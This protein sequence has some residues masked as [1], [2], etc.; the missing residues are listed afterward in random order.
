[1]N[2]LKIKFATLRGNMSAEGQRRLKAKMYDAG[3]KQM[4]VWVKRKDPKNITSMSRENF[5]EKVDKLTA[6]LSEIE[7]RNLFNM[8]LKIVT[9]HK[10]ELKRK[11]SSRK[12]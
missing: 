11:R 1:M 5:I 10:E 6:G 4:V 9:G 8:L 2:V 3:L 12:L 7:Q